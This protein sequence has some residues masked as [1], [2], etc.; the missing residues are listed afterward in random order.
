MAC[1]TLRIKGSY[2]YAKYLLADNGIVNHA[3]GADMG[4]ARMGC[5][6]AWMIGLCPS[7]AQHDP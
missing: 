4:A 7:G 2:R 5:V 3:Y 6:Y 1:E